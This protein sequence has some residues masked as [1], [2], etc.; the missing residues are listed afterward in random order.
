M[1]LIIT[2]Q[3]VCDG[4]VTDCFA[5]LLA[6]K[7]TALGS[8]VC[9]LNFAPD[10][11]TD[12]SRTIYSQLGQGCDLLLVTGGMS[13]GVDDVTPS[14][15]RLAGERID[16]AAFKSLGHGGFCRGCRECIHPA[17][18]FGKRACK[19]AISAVA[20]RHKGGETA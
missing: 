13:L 3:K 15:I 2:S 9:C 16:R 14:G 4:L 1:A 8:Q 10:D 5:P 19:A 11:E 20:T 18:A 7:M 12:R 6:D 17:C